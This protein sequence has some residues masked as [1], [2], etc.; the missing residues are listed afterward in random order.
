MAVAR[1]DIIKDFFNLAQNQHLGVVPDSLQLNPYWVIAVFPFQEEV[2]FQRSTMKSYD[3]DPSQAVKTTGEPLIITSDC[4]TLQ[5]HSSKDNFQGGLQAQL[6]PGNVDYTA[7]VVPGD[8]CL[9]WILQSETQA[10]NLLQRIK[11]LDPSKPCNNFMDGLKFVGRVLSCRKVL[12]QNPGGPRTAEY[13]LQAKSFSEFEAEVF[14]DPNLSTAVLA[15]GAFLAKLTQDISGIIGQS[16]QGVK[17]QE[18]GP[19]FLTL[20]LGKGLPTTV[21]IPGQ[22]KTGPKSKPREAPTAGVGLSGQDPGV[23]E[24]EGTLRISG[25][26]GGRRSFGEGHD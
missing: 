6:R 24:E 14:Y 19:Y 9:A 5:V 16:G 22:G 25:P 7:R 10:K 26:S 20:L 3:P 15:I 1:Y 2:T 13:S 4:H 18:I 23:P 8:W 12:T 21:T 11:A 17:T